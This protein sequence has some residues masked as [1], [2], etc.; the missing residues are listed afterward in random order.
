[1]VHVW[2]YLFTISFTCDRAL[3]LRRPN[4]S[5]IALWLLPVLVLVTIFINI[6]FILQQVRFELFNRFMF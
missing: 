3:V 5:S 4:S 1:M 6:F 2:L